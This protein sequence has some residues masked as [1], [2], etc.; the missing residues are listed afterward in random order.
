V[1]Q[2]EDGST[3]VQLTLRP[4]AC[5]AFSVNDVLLLSKDN[6]DVG[7]IVFS[8][9]RGN[10]LD[11]ITND[12]NLPSNLPS[13]FCVVQSGPGSSGCQALCLVEGHEGEHSLRVR[14]KLDVVRTKGKTPQEEKRCAGRNTIDR[15]EYIHHSLCC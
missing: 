9:Y 8:A 12:L 14:F 4:G 13:Y 11:F 15:K 10:C 1:E 7:L 5:S 3:V 6:P 2:R